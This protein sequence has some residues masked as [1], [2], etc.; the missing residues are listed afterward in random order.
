MRKEHL[1]PDGWK[2]CNAKTRDCQY[3]EVRVSG[4][5]SSVPSPA[6]ID[7]AVEEVKAHKPNAIRNFFNTLFGAGSKTP[8]EA[9][10]SPEVFSSTVKPKPV[11]IVLASP[12]VPAVP[13]VGEVMQGENGRYKVLCRG[14]WDTD[15]YLHTFGDLIT[16]RATVEKLHLADL[17]K[18]YQL[19]DCG[20][21]ARELW[22]RNEYVKEFCM[23][24]SPHGPKSGLHQFVKLQDGTYADSLGLWSEE[25]FLS[26]WTD[27]DPDGKIYPYEPDEGSSQNSE[28]SVRNLELFNTV[29]EAITKHMNGAV[30]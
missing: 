16:D 21:F 17:H 3:K 25:A 15:L 14:T 28:Y 23:F 1:T 12:V 10:V 13:I 18:D 7:G 27:F 20:V 2:P 26:Y 22:N 4:A 30:K 6:F 24:N 11:T 9:S 5:V 29:N 19:G 8:V